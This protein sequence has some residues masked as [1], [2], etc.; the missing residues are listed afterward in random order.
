MFGQVNIKIHEIKCDPERFQAIWDRAK[1]CEIR[2]ND[3]YYAVGDILKIHEYDRE[4]LRFT[5]RECKRK[6]SHIQHGYGLETEY[7]VLSFAHDLGR[8][9]KQ[10]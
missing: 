5:G 2:L 9:D 4:I 7:V 8:N 10:K 6:I 1:T 3:R